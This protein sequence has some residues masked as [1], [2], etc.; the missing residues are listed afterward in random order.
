MLAADVLAVHSLPDPLAS[1]P[2]ILLVDDEPSL[3]RSLARALRAL[4]PSWNVHV[5][6]SGTE[7]L[8]SLERYTYHAVVTDIEMPGLDGLALLARVRSAHPDVARLVHSSRLQDEP[9]HGVPHVA[10]G[11]LAKPAHPKR[12]VSL[13]EDALGQKAA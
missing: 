4:R 2:R 9:W 8:L 12:L 3:L 11:A 5:A 10:Q 6:E 7:A 1:I 13:I